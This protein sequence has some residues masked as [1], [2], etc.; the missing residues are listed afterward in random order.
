MMTLNPVQLEEM[1]PEDQRNAK[2][3]ATLMVASKVLTLFEHINVETEEG[4][5]AA[6]LALM[7]FVRVGRELH[8]TGAELGSATMALA[9]E[10]DFKLSEIFISEVA[11]A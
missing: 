2:L 8:T 10:L 11:H 4:A 6:T 3:I 7:E 1:L 9:M 5:R